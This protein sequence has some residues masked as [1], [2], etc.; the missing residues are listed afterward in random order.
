[1]PPPSGAIA[2]SAATAATSSAPAAPGAVRGVT[3]REIRSG[4]VMPFSGSI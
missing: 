2:A 4:M 3:D 1:V